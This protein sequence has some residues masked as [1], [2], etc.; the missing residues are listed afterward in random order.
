MAD[1]SVIA[2]LTFLHILSAMGWLGG[3][4]F[5]LSAIGP[6]VRSFTPP[7]S[8]EFLTKVGPRQLRYF[9][10]AAT[11]TIVF[12]L[13]LLFATFG[14]DYSTWPGYIEVGFG[15]GFIAYLIAVLVTI[16]TFRKV[17]KI[18]HQ[19]M[20]SPQAGPPP[21]EFPKLLKRANMAAMAVA[22]I[23][24]VTLVFMVSSAVF[25]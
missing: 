6:A 19:M 21:P 4:I 15:L 3:V 14:S 13:G 18:A 22:G 23:L 17:D 5:F 1:S 25:S 7:A 9:A 10:G 12:G 11:A 2:V 20:A 24:L 16:P 8:L